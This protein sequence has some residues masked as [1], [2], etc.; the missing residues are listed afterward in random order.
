[1]STQNKLKAIW[2]AAFLLLLAASLSNGIESE[3][4]FGIDIVFH[5]GIYAI[6]SVVPLLI[7]RKRFTAFIVA[8]AIA[9]LGFLFETMH[10]SISGYGFKMSDAFYN[11]VGISIGLVAGVIIR[12]K[13]HFANQPDNDA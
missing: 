5:I 12:L 9:P 11:N 8:I 7:L 2:L 3:R 1:M 4:A 13:H 6:L 10:G